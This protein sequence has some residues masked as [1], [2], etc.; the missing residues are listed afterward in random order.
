MSVANVGWRRCGCGGLAMSGTVVYVRVAE[1][2]ERGSAARPSSGRPLLP[3]VLS[4]LALRWAR[5][6]SSQTSTTHPSAR[7]AS[8]THTL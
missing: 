5:W 6:N 1:L 8:R 3:A 2:R 4:V 7:R